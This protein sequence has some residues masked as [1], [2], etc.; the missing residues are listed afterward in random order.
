[1][2]SEDGEHWTTQPGHILAPPG[3]TPTDRAK[4][5]HPN[6]IVDGRATRT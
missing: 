6:V 4:V 2:R 5:Q 1:M 3:R